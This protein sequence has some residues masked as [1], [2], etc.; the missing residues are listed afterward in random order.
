MRKYLLFALLAAALSTGGCTNMTKQQQGTLSGTAIGAAGGAGIAA[1]AGGDA[2][3]G[4][5]VV[6]V[7]G[8]SA[9]HVEE[10]R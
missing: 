8:G 1:I 2:G 10:S 4:A 5:I 6:G 7:I 9:G 3:V